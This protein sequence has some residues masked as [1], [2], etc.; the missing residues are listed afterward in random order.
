V[1]V[2]PEILEAQKIPVDNLDKNDLWEQRFRSIN[3]LERHL[4]NSGTRII[5]IF[6]HLS[7]D[8]QRK[9]ELQLFKQKLLK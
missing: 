2:H 6:L 1:R 3:N 5:K 4:Y 9:L 8:E 7:K